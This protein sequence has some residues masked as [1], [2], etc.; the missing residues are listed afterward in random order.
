MVQENA[1]KFPDRS[2]V[3][4][5]V[6]PQKQLWPPPGHSDTQEH[7]EVL[8]LRALVPWGCSSKIPQPA[9]P[10]PQQTLL[11]VLET[12]G[13]QSSASDMDG[14]GTGS[15]RSTIRDHR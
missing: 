1:D 10:Y 4:K 3:K 11:S 9:C 7:V 15:C 14:I 5:T 13:L 8:E 2:S 12:R 6:M